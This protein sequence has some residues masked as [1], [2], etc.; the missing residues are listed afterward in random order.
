MVLFYSNLRSLSVRQ[1]IASL[2]KD[3]KG[4]ALIYGPLTAKLGRTFLITNRKLIAKC[5]IANG[6]SDIAFKILDE[7]SLVHDRWKST[8]LATLLLLLKIDTLSPKF[9]PD[10]QTKRSETIQKLMVNMTVLENH[11]LGALLIPKIH[12]ILIDPFDCMEAVNGLKPNFQVFKRHADAALL[13]GTIANSIYGAAL[14]IHTFAQLSEDMLI[15]TSRTLALNA[16]IEESPEKKSKMFD[17]VLDQCKGGLR[18]HKRYLQHLVCLMGFNLAKKRR[19]SEEFGPL[20]SEYGRKFLVE[21]LEMSKVFDTIQKPLLQNVYNT[22]TSIDVENDKPIFAYMMGSFST[23]IYAHSEPSNISAR[24]PISDIPVSLMSELQQFKNKRSQSPTTHVNLL[25]IDDFKD[26]SYGEIE[27]FHTDLINY[28]VYLEKELLNWD[29]SPKGERYLALYHR[30]EKL[31]RYLKDKF[32]NEYYPFN[33]GEC[34]NQPGVA[35]S[36]LNSL[37]NPANTINSSIYDEV[38][39]LAGKFDIESSERVSAK[40][41]S[42]KSSRSA[43]SKKQ[44]P[45]KLCV[46]AFVSQ[47]DADVILKTRETVSRANTAPA[48]EFEKTLEENIKPAEDPTIDVVKNPVVTTPLT[49]PSLEFHSTM[50]F[51]RAPSTKL[52]TEIKIL[53]NVPVLMIDLLR[54]INQ[55]VYVSLNSFFSTQSELFL[56]EAEE[57]W[58]L[59]TDLLAKLMM[60]NSKSNQVTI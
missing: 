11:P 19:N 1:Y 54:H 56:V 33:L 58:L 35:C 2:N 3:D 48:P 23:Y 15:R 22:I 6:L 18:V 43:L 55:R 32:S 42:F 14:E 51:S 57:N 26:T 60:N 39:E 25:L 40:S 29:E 41:V 59:T 31:H 12:D 20:F 7:A 52:L 17:L 36:W 34:L 24:I 9:T 49:L 8:T 27:I 4:R 44:P 45:P 5:Y 28:K 13:L 47:M 46:F 38:K 50:L 53:R 16:Y 37:P 30:L 10:Y 21:F